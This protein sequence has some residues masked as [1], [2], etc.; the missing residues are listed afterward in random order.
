MLFISIDD[1]FQKAFNMTRLSRED[2]KNAALKMKENDAEAR[3][4]IINSYLPIVAGCI[5]RWPERIQTLDTAYRCIL[6]LEQGVDSFN[7][8]QD[9]E[10]FMHHLSWRLRQCLTK[11]LVD[12]P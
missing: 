11:C 1:F 7:F 6:S 4:A 5:K 8:L 2:E 3:Q 10:T 9:G 12:R